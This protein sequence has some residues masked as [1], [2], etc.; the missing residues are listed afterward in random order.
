MVSPIG[1][2]RDSTWAGLLDG[3]S[4]AGQVTTF[5]A[6]RHTTRI[7]CEVKGFDPLKYFEKVDA[8]R[9][10]PFTQY[11]IVATDEAM[12]HSG[13]NMDHEDT[14][15]AGC[16][17]GTGIGG[18]TTI[19]D[20]KDIFIERGP[21]RVS[22]FFIPRLMSNASA[23]Q[24]SIRYGFL[25]TS[26]TTGSACASSSNALGMALR[27]IQYGE[28]DIMLSGGSE[29]ATTELSLAGFCSMK[30]V[31]RRN[32][33]PTRASRPFDKDRDGFVM[34][35][36]AAAIVL[37][38][39]EHARKRGA[40]II[41]EFVGYGSTDDAFHITAPAEDGKGPMRAMQLAL[42]DG[43]LQPEDVDYLNAHGTST[44]LNDKV[45]TLAIR[46]VFGDAANRLQ[47]SSTKSMTGHLLGASGAVEFAISALTIKTGRI[48]PTINYE[49][50]D[51]ECDLDYVPN[52]VRESDVRT[53]MSNSLGFG[54]HNTCL[55]LERFS[56]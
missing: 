34:G 30:A 3:V 37:E 56:D 23:G 6:S 8:R 32:D 38:E 29:C 25:G 18:I 16:I 42:A 52:E 51:P 24:T 28:A 31:S 55:V 13:L 9:M 7:A 54:G 21:S 11:Q 44:Y 14:T 5:D 26:F 45:E 41:A 1:L 48:P 4:G 27:A 10:D 46:S 35:A 39:L 49:T 53:A 33:D 15:R 40:E 36:G 2:D 19:E 17:L 20:Q 12:K 43:K 22:P 47:I 50:P